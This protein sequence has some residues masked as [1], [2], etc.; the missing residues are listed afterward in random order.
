MSAR[1]VPLLLLGFLVVLPSPAALP[2]LPELAQPKEV[3]AIAR[4][5]ALPPTRPWDEPFRVERHPFTAAAL[6]GYAADGPAEEAQKYPL[7]VAVLKA[8]Q[9]VRDVWATP[10]P[11]RPLPKGKAPRPKKGKKEPARPSFLTAI[12]APLTDLTK[13]D[14]KEYQVLP[15]VGIVKLEEAIGELERVAP[16]RAKE[17]RRWQAHYDYAL[18]G[19]LARVAFLHE[20]NLVLGH[21]LREELPELGE[22]RAG[23]RMVPSAKMHSRGD[24]RELD[25]RARELFEKLKA[26]HKGTPWAAVAARELVAPPGLAWEP[27][28]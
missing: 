2:S 7:R 6:R 23:W 17:P 4:E 5:C 24:V 26:D 16:L 10:A 9:T 8:F 12:P 1:R 21:A 3:A 20:Y 28:K 14:V 11:P 13:Q 19:C 27:A 18:A 15:A 25:R 22:G